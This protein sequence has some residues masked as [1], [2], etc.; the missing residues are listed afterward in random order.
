V[1]SAVF[2]AASTSAPGSRGAGNPFHSVPSFQ[3]MHLESQYSICTIMTGC[4]LWCIAFFFESLLAL[5][6]L[7]LNYPSGGSESEKG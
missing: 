6:L 1:C 2:L 3:S 4:N 5:L 7:F